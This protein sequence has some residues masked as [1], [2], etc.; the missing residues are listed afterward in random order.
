MN[1]TYSIEFTSL[2]KMSEAEYAL[3]IVRMEQLKTLYPA[4]AVA[5]A[6]QVQRAFAQAMGEHPLAT[7]YKRKTGEK[8]AAVSAVDAERFTRTKEKA[9]YAVTKGIEVPLEVK[10][11]VWKGRLLERGMASAEEI[12]TAI[13]SAGNGASYESEPLPEIEMDGDADAGIDAL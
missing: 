5:Q 7:L 8:K 4:T 6:P 12:E 10:I 11:A 13:E 1:V 2:G 9:G 3:A